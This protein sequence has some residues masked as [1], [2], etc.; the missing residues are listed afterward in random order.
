MKWLTFDEGGTVRHGYLDGD[1]I[2]VTGDGDL[3]AVVRG[4]SGTGVRERRPVQGVRILAPLL[5]P[6]KVI[7][8]AANYQEHVKESGSEARDQKTATPRLFL[9]PD[10]AI[11]GP[12]APVVLNPIT[13]QLDWE[14]EIAAVVGRR[15]SSVPVAQALDHVF[16]YTT[17][18]DISARSLDLD[19]PRDGE[20]WT[21]FFDWLEGKWLD[22]S[23][24]MGP[25]LV[26]TDE[27]PDPQNLELT[28]EL[29]GQIMQRGSSTDMVH[30]VAELVSFSSRLM[31]LNPG[32]VILTGTP[33]GVGA[34]TGVFLKPGDRMVAEVEG[35]GPLTTPVVAS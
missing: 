12:D 10:T 35:L 6:G 2:V 32:D 19:V 26:T 30:T 7:A 1:E 20:A 16:G 25:Y 28:L 27:V 22:G 9:K 3:A 11:T 21:G 14:V 31:T 5:T 13:S 8:V 23:A 15:A 24:P 4:E 33:S 29:N 18:N 17:S 34:T